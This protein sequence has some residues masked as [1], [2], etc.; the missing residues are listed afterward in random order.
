MVPGF[1]RG[2]P[3]P[4]NPVPLALRLSG[5]DFRGC[6]ACRDPVPQGV[7]RARG[8]VARA[9]STASQASGGR[10]PKRSL[11]GVSEGRMPERTRGEM[12]RATPTHARRDPRKSLSSR[13]FSVRTE[14]ADTRGPQDQ[15]VVHPGRAEREPL[16]L[17]VIHGRGINAPLLHESD[18]PMDRAER[19]EPGQQAAP[20]ERDENAAGQKPPGGASRGDGFA[21][22]STTFRNSQPKVRLA[23]AS[24]RTRLSDCPAT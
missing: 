3:V 4:V 2:I 14:T 7:Y 15:H 21:H 1:C 22:G 10:M 16:E 5:L 17:G 13:G 24:V 11:R 12:A 23:I 18:M 9:S 8:G 20:D 6:V 19:E